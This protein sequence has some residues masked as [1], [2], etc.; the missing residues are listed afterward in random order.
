MCPLDS[1]PPQLSY[2]LRSPGVFPLSHDPRHPPTSKKQFPWETS[3]V[4]GSRVVR[5]PVRKTSPLRPR[6]PPYRTGAGGLGTDDP[7]PKRPT[8]S[9]AGWCLWVPGQDPGWGG[10][11]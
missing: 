11:G 8:G 3:P 5:P 2:D 10:G 9:G 7:D 1:G 4:F 6:V